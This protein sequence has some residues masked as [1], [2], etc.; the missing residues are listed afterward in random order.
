VLL[1]ATIYVLINL[2][3]DILYLY[4]DPRLQHA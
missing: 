1:V 2:G 3:T 4:L